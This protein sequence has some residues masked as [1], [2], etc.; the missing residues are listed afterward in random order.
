MQQEGELYVF[1]FKGARY[2]IPVDY[3]DQLVRY[4]GDQRDPTVEGWI[5]SLRET[6]RAHVIVEKIL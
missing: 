4:W 2:K 5:G 3:R 1:E 6:M